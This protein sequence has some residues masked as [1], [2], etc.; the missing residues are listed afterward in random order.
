[1]NL[2]LMGGVV[3]ILEKLLVKVRVPSVTSQRTEL[4]FK[5]NLT[6]HQGK[7]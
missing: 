1:M 5:H 4:V 7:L 6:E 2:W 3:S